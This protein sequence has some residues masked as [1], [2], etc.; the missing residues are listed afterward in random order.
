MK[1]ARTFTAV[2]A[3]LLIATSAHADCG[4]NATYVGDGKYN[5]D[6]MFLT[7]AS[8]APRVAAFCKC[9]ENANDFYI[10]Q[11]NMWG[12]RFFCLGPGQSAVPAHPNA[13]PIIPVMPF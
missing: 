9:K 13:V 3:L 5:V 7:E 12:G 2:T 10:N 4:L 11:A 8:F 6:E 1:H